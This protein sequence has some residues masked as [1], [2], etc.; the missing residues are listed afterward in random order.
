MESAQADSHL[1]FMLKNDNVDIELICIQLLF[2]CDCAIFFTLLL[3]PFEF[4]TVLGQM[5]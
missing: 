5:R 4:E 1:V 2:H 3:M